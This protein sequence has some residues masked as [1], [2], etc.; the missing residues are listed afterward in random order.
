MNRYDIILEKELPAPVEADI[1]CDPSSPFA[2][3]DALMEPITVQITMEKNRVNVCRTDRYV[4]L[5]N[6]DLFLG[7]MRYKDG[8]IYINEKGEVARI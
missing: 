5:R 2:W 3:L 4:L 6:G 1:R 7:E 8:D